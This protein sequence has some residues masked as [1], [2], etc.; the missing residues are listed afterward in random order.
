MKLETKLETKPGTPP[1]VPGDGG[2]SG[3]LEVEGSSLIQA[4]RYQEEEQVLEVQFHGK[5]IYAY[6][7]VPEDVFEALQAAPSIGSFF[8][9]H[10]KT[11]FEYTRVVDSE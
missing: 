7:A 1:M 11:K 9:R 4:V 2:Q 10:I 3:W 8:S 6:S 5:R